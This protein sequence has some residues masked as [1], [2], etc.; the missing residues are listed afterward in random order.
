M[1]KMPLLLL[2]LFI[3]TSSFAQSSGDI[4][5]IPQPV[6]LKRLDDRFTFPSN[7]VI[8]TTAPGLDVAGYLGKKISAAMGY[9]V[10]IKDKL[11]SAS[12]TIKFFLVKDKLFNK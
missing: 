9:K 3:I 2:S 6:S 5:L 1:R 11:T 12:G 10:T 7:P 4:S 8:E